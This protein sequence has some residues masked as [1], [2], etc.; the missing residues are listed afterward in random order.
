M[1]L[2]ICLN[3]TLYGV[4]NLDSVA[5]SYGSV[6]TFVCFEEKIIWRNVS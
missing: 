4:P 5:K 1:V 2:I 6:G 3:I